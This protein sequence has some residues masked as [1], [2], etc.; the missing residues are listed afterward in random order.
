MNEESKCP[1]RKWWMGWP[2]FFRI[3]AG[4]AILVL[5]WLL[6]SLEGGMDLDDFARSVLGLPVI[7]CKAEAGFGALVL[8]AFLVFW[9]WRALIRG[10]SRKWWMGWPA[11]FRILSGSAI[12]VL[13]WLLVSLEQ[14]TNADDLISSDLGPPVI[15]CKAAAGFVGVVLFAFLVFW[16]RRALIWL[17]RWRMIRRY[18]YA[19]PGVA[20]LVALFYA[21]EDWRGKRD[22]E[23]YKR[24][25]EAK[26][27]RFELSSY[28]PPSVPDDQNFVFAP[29]V[30]NSCLFRTDGDVPGLP[31]A[32]TN[33]G[34]LLDIRINANYEWKPWPTNNLLGNWQCGDK[35]D[36]RAFQTYYRAPANS[37]W[38]TNLYAARQG[39]VGLYGKRL[40]PALPASVPE[41]V[42][43]NEFPVA[44]QPQS[45][46]A[47]VLLALSKYDSAIEELRQASRHPFFQFP[48]QNRPATPTDKFVTPTLVPLKECLG[49]LRLRAVAELENIQ[50]DK[51]LAD[52]TLMLYLANL[53]HHEPWRELWCQNW[54]INSID[55]ALQPVWQGLVGHQWSDTQLTRIG[56]ELAKFDFLSDYQH[57][58]RCWR[59]ETLQEIDSIEQGRFHEFWA[60]LHVGPDQDNSSLWE[61]VFN[62]NT[63]FTFMPKGWF[64]ENDV[65]VAQ[66]FQQSLRTDAEA[67]QRILSSELIKRVEDAQEYNCRHQS[68][69]N[70]AAS[71]MYPGSARLAQKFAFTQSSLDRARVAC[72]L[73][74]YR[75][76]EGVYPATLDMLTPRFIE[77]LPNDVIN[78]QPLHYQRIADGRFLLYSVGWNGTDDAGTLVRD[79][80]RRNTLDQLQG[81]WV[82]PFP[83]GLWHMTARTKPAP[84]PSYCLCRAENPL[85]LP[86]STKIKSGLS[87]P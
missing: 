38:R 19:L 41:Q 79:K 10:P 37:N 6:V 1:G 49:V 78:G 63:L 71:M 23:Q 2:A 32:N 64:Y 82:W 51:A 52:V 3:L 21:E 69:R 33:R 75:L 67:G 30:S 5:I 14:G 35:T 36:L 74:R 72:A 53:N 8:F 48:P 45:P 40:R 80:Y 60:M 12:L 54:R 44:P 26:G 11:F 47:D 9:T 57:F 28:Q 4:A 70:F 31:N 18:L 84:G 61:R 7:I 42:A 66:M 16:T 85:S 87:A 56:S 83:N 39:S 34:R 46:A 15:F 68:L 73:E 59:A 58:V 13:I 86:E 29:I 17:F 65:A 77:K 50:G 55:S 20:V 76:A 62:E 27:E 22:W 81:D 43:T 25:A 24:A